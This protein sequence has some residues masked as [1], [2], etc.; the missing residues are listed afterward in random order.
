MK[1]QHVANVEVEGVGDDFT[2]VV[3]RLPV[4]GGWLYL[5]THYHLEGRR[6][7]P[8]GFVPRPRHDAHDLGEEE[9]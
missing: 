2:L 7:V 9:P 6:V 4:P 1:E 3:Y 5:G 8:L